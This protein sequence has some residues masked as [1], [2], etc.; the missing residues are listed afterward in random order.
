MTLEWEQIKSNLS[1]YIYRSKIQGGWLVMC[2]EDVLTT[3][4]E[5]QPNQIGYQWRS[6]ITF[7]PDINHTWSI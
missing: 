2:T 7:V 1:S 5:Y 3:M 4:D 6:S